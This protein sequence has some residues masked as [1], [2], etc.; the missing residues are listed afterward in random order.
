MTSKA[1][2]KYLL[3]DS[4]QKKFVDLIIEHMLIKYVRYVLIPEKSSCHHTKK[5]RRQGK[6]MERD[7]CP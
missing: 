7:L 5:E 3:Y 6:A 2:K 4:L 1:K